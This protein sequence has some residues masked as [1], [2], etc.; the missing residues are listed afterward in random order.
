MNAS[1]SLL[2]RL[3]TAFPLDPSSPTPL[4]HQVQQLLRRGV[5]RGL[6]APEQAIPA[7][8][9]LAQGL[10]V[11]RVTVRKALDGLVEDGLLSR[12]QGAGTFV[13]P[14]VEQPLS[15]LTSFSEDMSARGIQ[16]GAVWLERTLSIPSPEEA[17]ALNLSPGEEVVRLHRLRTADGK[18][19]ALE[20]ATVPRALLPSPELVGQSL[21]QALARLGYRPVRALQRLRAESLSPEQARLLHVSAGAPALY[22]ERR[23]FL[24]DGRPVEFTRSHYRGD[25]YDFVAELKIDR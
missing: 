12:R 13:S 20:L 10:G 17:M 8:R 22:I 3:L 14:R 2:A 23:S 19:M 4:Y 16:A 6:L 25:A 15:Y 1:A 11:S 5:E 21:Y 18:P 9:D 7:E 24:A